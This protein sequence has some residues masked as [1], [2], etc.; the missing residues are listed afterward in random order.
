MPVDEIVVNT[1]DPPPSLSDAP[2]DVVETVYEPEQKVVQIFPD[3]YVAK[4]VEFYN[5]RVP[6]YN[7]RNK[8]NLPLS[9]DPSDD[10]YLAVDRDFKN[11]RVEIYNSVNKKFGLGLPEVQ[12]ANEIT[13]DNERKI[14]EVQVASVLNNA[15]KELKLAQAIFP[16][17]KSFKP[18][19]D[20]ADIQARGTEYETKIKQA[21]SASTKSEQQKLVSSLNAYVE[22]FNKQ[23]G[24]KLPAFKDYAS[25]KKA[26]TPNKDG[27]TPFGK[28]LDI[29]QSEHPIVEP[30]TLQ[31]AK[32][33][34]DKLGRAENEEMRK[35]ADFVYHISEN[36]RAAKAAA[37]KENALRLQK[38]TLKSKGHS[39]P[40]LEPFDIQYLSSVKGDE[41]YHQDAAEITAKRTIEFQNKANE[42]MPEFKSLQQSINQKTQEG[43]IVP[44]A[45]ID[46]Y[47]VVK[48]DI[49]NLLDAADVMDN[50]AKKK[51]AELFKIK[52]EQGNFL[53][54]GGRVGLSTLGDLSKS[55]SNLFLSALSYDPIANQLGFG[56]EEANKLIGDVDKSIDFVEQEMS[57]KLGLASKEYVESQGGLRKAAYD[58][59]GI[60]PYVAASELKVPGLT[61]AMMTTQGY[62]AEKRQ[63][64]SDPKFNSL[65]PEQK[66]VVALTKGLV[67]AI[68]ME[69]GLKLGKSGTMINNLTYDAIKSGAAR[70]GFNSANSYLRRKAVEYTSGVVSQGVSFGALNFAGTFANHGTNEIINAIKGEDLFEMPSAGQMLTEA[71]QSAEEGILTGALLGAGTGI[72][73]AVKKGK[74]DFDEF[75][76]INE[77]FD[78]PAAFDLYAA[79]IRQQVIDKKITK[80]EASEH[81]KALTQYRDVASQIPKDMP[82][83]PRFE[84][85]TLML[86]NK[87]LE[88][89]K[90]GLNPLF[91]KT[92][93]KRIAE[94]EKAIVEIADNTD[95]DNNSENKLPLQNTITNGR[96]PTGNNQDFKETTTKSITEKGKSIAEKVRSLKSDG[97]QTD[98]TLGLKDMALEEIAS[99]IEDGAV[100][101]DAIA[102][103]LKDEKYDKL[104]KDELKKLVYGANPL[105]EK[106]FENA[107]KKALI[108]EL[109]DRGYN[110]TEA[111]FIAENGFEGIKKV[112]DTRSLNK[113]LG[114]DV[115]QKPIKLTVNEKSALR[116]QIKF[117][118]RAAKEGAKSVTDGLKGVA[119]VVNEI[120]KEH[121]TKISTKQLNAIQKRAAMLK[122]GSTESVRKY[123]DYV[124][125]VLANAEYADQLSE[126]KSTSKKIKKLIKNDKIPAAVR[127]AANEFISLDAADVRNLNKHQAIMNELYDA[128][129]SG[130]IK[131]Q[132]GQI[133]DKTRKAADLDKINE[134]I[135]KEMELAAKREQESMSEEYEET[136]ENLA[137]DEAADAPERIKEYVKNKYAKLSRMVQDMIINRS[138]SNSLPDNKP[139]IERQLA[140]I[141]NGDVVTFVYDKES[142]IPEV[143]RDKVSSKGENNGK[144]FWHVTVAQSLADYELNKSSTELSLL[145]GTRADFSKEELSMMKKMANLKLDQF[146]NVKDWYEATEALDHLLTNGD[147]GLIPHILNKYENAVIVNKGLETLKTKLGGKIA[148][149]PITRAFAGLEAL[150]KSRAKDS[151]AEKV[152]FENTSFRR[153]DNLLKNWKD[154]GIY[155]GTFYHLAQGQ[156]NYKTLAR[157]MDADRIQKELF[158]GNGYDQKKNLLSKY[159]ITAFLRQLE[160]ESNPESKSNRPA[161]DYLNATVEAAEYKEHPIQG[162]ALELLKDVIAEYSTDG[163]ID[164]KK[165]EKGLTPQEKAAIAGL[166]KLYKDLAP[167]H[168]KVSLAIRNKPFTAIDN[169][170][171]ISAYSKDN[172]ILSPSETKRQYMNVLQGT[173]SGTIEERSGAASAINMDPFASA[174]KAVRDVML[175]YWMTN[176]FKNVEKI[177]TKF[178]DYAVDEKKKFPRGTPE[179]ENAVKRENIADAWLGIFND[180]R[181]NMLMRSYY[182]STPLKKFTQLVQKR[183]VQYTLARPARL[184]AELTSNTSFVMSSATKEFLLGTTKYREYNGHDQAKIMANLS[185]SATERLH[186]HG[187]MATSVMDTQDFDISV[188]DNQNLVS[189]AKRKALQV[190]YYT[191]ARAIGKGEAASEWAITKGDLAIARPIWTGTM[192]TEFKKLTGKEIDFDKIMENDLEYI[193]ENESA[194]DKARTIADRKVTDA[195]ASKNPFE[196]SSKMST[197]STQVWQAINKYMRG[198]NMNEY[199]LAS[200][201]VMHLYN[202][203]KMSQADAIRILGGI[204]ARAGMY[205]VV[206]T[207]A[208]TAIMGGLMAGWAAM[209][210]DDK[211]YSELEKEIGADKP[212]T[213]ENRRKMAEKLLE[214]FG[215]E[216]DPLQ[217]GDEETI[218][219]WKSQAEEPNSFSEDFIQGVAQQYLSMFTQRNF[220]NIVQGYVTAPIFEQMINK[221]IREGMGLGYN[222]YKD[223]LLYSKLP[224]TDKRNW[225]V[226]SIEQGTGAYGTP[227]AMFMESALAGVNIRKDMAKLDE[228][229]KEIEAHKE[230][231]PVE[232]S[233][234]KDYYKLVEQKKTIEGR[235]MDNWAKIGK[236]TTIAIGML[237]GAIPGLKDIDKAWDKMLQ[238]KYRK[239]KDFKELM[240]NYELLKKGYH[241]QKEKEEKEVSE[242]YRATQAGHKI[243]PKD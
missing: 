222:P 187:G 102:K 22:D 140:D 217:T 230:G 93:D 129:K 21:T 7:A 243:P 152:F 95:A 202:G 105:T 28:Q 13:P 210:D 112:E 11:H 90:A 18:F 126:V 48:E 41:K 176:P 73:N 71:W 78:N 231:K 167:Y 94:N 37:L 2:Q 15:N 179:Y 43:L 132:D 45:E 33:I 213:P 169:Y 100:V 221:K 159:K 143:F 24:S 117:E 85:T 162:K 227:I 23:T 214:K 20:I 146:E 211:T 183:A 207:L 138:N 133:V 106:D 55:A 173:K 29:Y 219:F 151:H 75:K 108:S 212:D 114:T 92:I 72:V 101:V 103:V 192:A 232:N 184:L 44:Q 3:G 76:V 145:D 225:M 53:S 239:P 200:D 113:Q 31:P 241:I 157:Q 236:E 25:A 79:N 60:L 141:K 120:L 175:D 32:P 234:L 124:E 27:E 65:T 98:F 156:S 142:D 87:S 57:D 218:K 131:V 125:K 39:V 194:L 155:E 160:Y 17:L 51:Y 115:K 40:L 46:R 203:G 237:F 136:V 42:L 204:T 19:K 8:A 166:Q 118:V 177:L 181:E 199:E 188:S 174:N 150:F 182:E 229:N 191:I 81:L 226:N 215:K 233:S 49:K 99:L 6:A 30:I 82:L 139:S 195:A 205:K 64:N 84:V 228:V 235:I 104:D 172:K 116:D 206:Q 154:Y 149:L 216:G 223:G 9:D 240:E 36:E 137:S 54:G 111:T 70:M 161:I 107:D 12:S 96:T 127:R 16:E 47:N 62:A 35:K 89:Q 158:K 144:K 180:A 34:V 63:L 74:M 38:T 69:M 10:D 68:V 164:L 4:D 91:T 153:W 209:S 185:S 208:S 238:D 109:K 5:S 61:L 52:A 122:V 242:Y 83:R 220:G 14:D 26:I 190:Y 193:D 135:E 66:D 186:P 224:D 171:H 189:P 56:R 1:Q 198:F 197:R 50:T 170:S 110:S 168:T 123:V 163:Q 201:A 80:P 97:L 88:A 121:K 130:G 59:I 67:G 58:V 119:K 134:Y 77:M 178:K 148:E 86:E 196:T 165:L 147:M 128:M